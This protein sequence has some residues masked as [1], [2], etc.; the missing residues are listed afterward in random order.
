[1]EKNLL[2]VKNLSTHFQTD[3]GEVKA[4]NDVSF[5]VERGRTVCIVGESGCGKSVT[6]L[7]IMRLVDAPGKI[8]SGEILFDGNNLL[9]LSEGD[10]CD[11]RGNKLS[12][13]FQEPMTALNPV[14]TIG[15]QMVEPLMRHKMMSRRQALGKSIELIQKVGIPRPEKIAESYPHELSGG[16][17]Q[18]IMIATSLSCNPELLIADE[19]TTA[20]DVT[21]Q[22]QILD[23]LRALK[24]DLHMSMLFITHDLGVV[25]EIADEVVVMY[26][27]K[28]IEKAPVLDLFAHPQHPYTQGLLKCKPRIGEK[29]K[30]LYTIPGQ[31]PDLAGLHDCC[32]FH[33]R[34]TKCRDIC[35]NQSPHL[36]ASGDGHETACWLN[37]KEQPDE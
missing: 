31:V 37:G 22:A 33:D 20:L 19:P 24:E 30:R 2:E 29:R 11:L 28:V 12:M 32:Y 8:V 21:I 16:M 5:S 27:G 34:C 3:T 4:V 9:Q 36:T 26:A 17:L 14:L 18:R 35:R 10:M 23:L 25:A 1:V 7:S 6:S 13:I 15:Q